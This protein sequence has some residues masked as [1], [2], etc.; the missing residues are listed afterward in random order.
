MSYFRYFPDEFYRFGDEETTEIFANLSAYAE[1]V[2]EIK[3][4]IAFYEDYYVQEGER[5]DQLSFRLYDT[6]DYHW[7]FYLM[8]PKI[9][10]R[11]W[12][13]SNQEVIAKAQKDRSLVVVTT[14]TTLTD[15]MIP[16]QILTGASSGAT[17]YVEYRNLDLGQ[18]MVEMT[19][20]T[21]TAGETI[22]STNAD[23]QLES[24]VATS[25][26][27]EY[28]AARYYT[29]ASGVTTDIDPE[30]GPGALLTEVSH[31]DHYVEQN[32]ELKQI[33]IIKS[34]I[35]NSV[36]RSFREAIVS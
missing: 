25:V 19:S 3:D 24:I 36:V 7:T 20:G 27:P 29:D 35:I 10:E 12:P 32:D 16:Y 5:P 6:P 2:D 15:K 28:L 4:N 14:R 9:R 22:F 26:G 18:L 33:R 23:E 21:F 34:N 17:G 30:V 8:N 13:L 11:G 31:L 1:V